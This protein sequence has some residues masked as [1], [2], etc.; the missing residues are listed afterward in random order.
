MRLNSHRNDS[1][2]RQLNY[3]ELGAKRAGLVQ[4]LEGNESRIRT[5]DNCLTIQ[6]V[7]S[8]PSVPRMVM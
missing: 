3:D 5:K 8:C 1:A 6:A 2:T 7:G 4:L